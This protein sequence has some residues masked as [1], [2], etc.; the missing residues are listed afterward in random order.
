[1]PRENG[2]PEASEELTRLQQIA[3]RIYGQVPGLA[4]MGFAFWLAWNTVAFS[5]SFWLHDV[6]TSFR[7]EALKLVHLLTCVIVLVALGTTAK[8]S[9]KLV[10]NNVFLISGGLVGAVGTAVVVGAYYVPFP[11]SAIL[12]FVGIV[13][14]GLGT[15]VVFMRSA[16]LFGALPPN[17]AAALIAL[18]TM[19]SNGIFLALSCIDER[20]A[21]FCFILLP[22]LAV[23]FLLLR[24]G[25]GLANEKS[26]RTDAKA[27]RLFVVFLL[28]VLVCAA[29]L[30]MMRSYTL[31]HMPSALAIA[32]A[33]NANFIQIVVLFAFVVALLVMALGPKHLTNLYSAACALIVIMLAAIAILGPDTVVTSSIAIA[34][35]AFYNAI[36][37]ALLAY[38]VYQSQS[39]SVFVFGIGNAAL[40]GG[41]ILGI[42]AVMGYHA[43]IYD[44]SL[45]NPII[46]VTAAIV[47]VCALFVFT[48]KRMDD[49]IRPI[50]E[51]RSELSAFGEP[52]A[53]LPKQ[54]I[55]DCKRLASERGLSPREEEVFIELARGRTAQEI[56][57]AQTV[58]VYTVR[59]HIRAIY[60]K[61]EVHNRRELNALVE[62]NRTV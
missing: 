7:A 39:S 6:D 34:D 19:L 17:R 40:A 54:W 31:I 59:A 33:R 3:V 45:M 16:M 51:A 5:G 2:A 37:W 20:V 57:D 12:F 28:S 38:I 49:L 29:A 27:T 46:L 25:R 14:G 61:L 43:G 30:E 13:L 35:I 24:G 56:A 10:T 41:T 15:T 55:T 18:A 26:L 4:C 1:M 21:V 44:E 22:V 52:A 9:T 53:R 32:S 36:V 60:S 50:D 62:K 42:L 11:V 47:L 58:S 8:R 23:P 48:E